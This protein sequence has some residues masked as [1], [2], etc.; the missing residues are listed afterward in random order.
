MPRKPTKPPIAQPREV[1]AVDRFVSTPRDQEA[2]APAAPTKR[3]TIAVSD[4]LHRRIKLS[5]VA[6][7]INMADAVREAVERAPWPLSE[8]A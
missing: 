8:A 7:G 6:R 5:C 1:T 3:I 2:A 4:T